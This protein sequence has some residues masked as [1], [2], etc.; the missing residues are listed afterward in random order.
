MPKS[1]QL[2]PANFW[3]VKKQNPNL[4]VLLD[5]SAETKK[6]S[7]FLFIKKIFKKTQL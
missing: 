4:D 7:F 5:L 3:D 2:V 1:N 6:I